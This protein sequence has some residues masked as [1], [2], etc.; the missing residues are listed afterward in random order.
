[1]TSQGST[2]FWATDP[3]IK[4]PQDQAKAKLLFDVPDDQ[5]PSGV[6]SAQIRI[7][8]EPDGN[9]PAGGHI[10]TAF[11]ITAITPSDLTGFSGGGPTPITL[12][13]RYDPVACSIAPEAE[14]KFVLGRLNESGAWTE[15]CGDTANVTDHEVSCDNSDLSFGVFAVIPKGTGILND[16]D[17]PFFPET[18]AV[19]LTGTPCYACVPPYVLLEWSPASDGTGSGVRGYRIYVDGNR[20]TFVANVTGNP[21]IKFAFTPTGTVDIKQPHL[22][23]I[24][25]VDNAD[26]ESPL[27][28]ALR[29]P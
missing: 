6:L 21:T 4:L 24:T 9:L 12:T 20:D 19:S 10:D 25:A 23:Q 27:Y 5:L 26:N 29:L 13:I 17:P 15:V 1:M 14:A 28:G 8:P 2:L 11:R 3:Q 7:A 16:P 18:V 22:Y